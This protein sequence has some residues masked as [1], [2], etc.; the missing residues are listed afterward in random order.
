MTT[1]FLLYR[2]LLELSVPLE[3]LDPVVCLVFPVVKERKVSPLRLLILVA[4]ARKESPAWMVSVDLPDSLVK[5]GYQDTRA[6][7]ERLV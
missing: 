6:T 4:E 5:M 1:Y 2:E 7:K 3:T